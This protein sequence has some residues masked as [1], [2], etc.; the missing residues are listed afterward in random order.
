MQHV[1]SIMI[2]EVGSDAC[3][4]RHS[5]FFAT[6]GGREDYAFGSSAA[7][8]LSRLEAREAAFAQ[9]FTLGM[10]QECAFLAL[11]AMQQL[12]ESGRCDLETF[13]GQMG[14]MTEVVRHAPLLAQNW[15]QLK[16]EFPGVWLYEVTERF[17]REWAQLLLDGSNES[18]VERLRT[19]IE[20]LL[21]SGQ[22][23]SIP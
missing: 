17:G 14:F 4:S 16:D 2:G 10:A 6:R 8:A 13:G 5:R 7:Q 21:P 18:A 15:L 22:E 11:G 9:Q 23:D 20:D 19:I 3:P 12:T 1:V